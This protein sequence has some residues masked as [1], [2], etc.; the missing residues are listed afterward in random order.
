MSEDDVFEVLLREALE[1]EVDGGGLLAYNYLAGEPITGLAAG[2]PLFLRTPESSFT[3]ANTFRAQLYAVF[4][5][6]A[7]GLRILSGEGVGVQ[8]MFAHGGLFRTAGVAQ[9][10]LAGALDAPVVL[11]RAAPEGGA[12]GMAVLAAYLQHAR[13]VDLAGYLQSQVFADTPTEVVKPR[14]E[15]VTGFAA[16]LDTY[17]A[18]LAAERAA[19]QAL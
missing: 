5:T 16:F 10:F 9:R 3:L 14:R 11:N 8:R 19:V 2:V 4:G 6:M 13:T 1:G 15:D 12:W 18:G 17:R 7:L